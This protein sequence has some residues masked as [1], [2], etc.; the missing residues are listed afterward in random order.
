MEVF[1]IK[2]K[3]DITPIKKIP[4]HAKISKLD[5]KELKKASLHQIKIIRNPSDQEHHRAMTTDKPGMNRGKSFSESELHAAY[6]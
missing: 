5:T 3:P 6:Y 1:A 2:S 4:A